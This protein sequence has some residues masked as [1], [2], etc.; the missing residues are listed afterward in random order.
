MLS[1]P[2]GTGHR[3]TPGPGF[4]PYVMEYGE[5]PS[6]CPLKKRHC[7]SVRVF[8]KHGIPSVTSWRRPFLHQLKADN[9][10]A[11]SFSGWE[12]SGFVGGVGGESI[13]LP[14]ATMPGTAD[15]SG[16]MTSEYR[17]SFCQI[18]ALQQSTSLPPLRHSPFLPLPAS[19]LPS[20]HHRCHH[21]NF[22]H[23]SSSPPSHASAH[24]PSQ[25]SSV[26]TSKRTKC[27][28]LVLSAFPT[29]HVRGP[30]ASSKETD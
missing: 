7:H 6:S 15:P 17:F 19:V 16:Q 14:W 12:H 5:F 3:G 24:R 18:R 23:V 20:P 11:D 10:P 28:V 22:Y 27:H 26:T 4:R 2:P 25:G 1:L 21:Q 29:F 9:L 30:S 13:L 8:H